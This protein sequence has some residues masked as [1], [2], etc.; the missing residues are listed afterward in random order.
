MPA[1]LF[2]KMFPTLNDLLDYLL[3]I[4]LP[5]TIQT[6]G[7]FVALAFV[8]A[9]QVFRS[10]FKRYEGLGKIGAV[11]KI[12]IAGGT[13]AI[14]SVLLNLLL[15]FLLGYKVGGPFFQYDA[16]VSDPR[17]YIF[18][19]Q[20]SLT[21]GALT[22]ILFA[23]WAY[24]DQKDELE[25]KTARPIRKIV[26]PYQL[27]G[28][29]VI[30]VGLT[31]VIGAKLFDIVEHL[32]ALRYNPVNALFKNTG[33]NY[34]GGLIFGA[35]TYLYIGHRHG[36]KLVHLADIGSPGMMLAYG[37]GRIGCQLAGD[38]DWGIVNI[39]SMPGLLSWLP[40][41]AWSSLY[42]HNAIDAGVY[43]QG[44]SGTH[45]N[46]LVQG[47][48]PTPFY[49]AV[50]CI[51]LF[52]LMWVLRKRIVLPGLMF[53]LYLV[54][55]G[56]ERLLIEFIRVNPRYELFGMHFTQA[57]IIATLML[58]GGIAGL[59]YLFFVQRKYCNFE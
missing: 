43:I 4:K 16:F 35:L 33:Y 50:L 32:P 8:A 54:L 14:V 10:E 57:Q 52:V 15:G 20:G 2:K 37:V 47:V 27:M 56:A 30:A 34:Y 29:V 1:F 3:R 42:P 11:V 41:W 39:H 18:S 9:Y 49:E 48:Y 36:M 7:F 58:L 6:L 23:L 26:H 38:G 19:F 59:V 55:C 28:T 53:C 31:G 25:I 24:L 5:I 13:S 45:C 21:A 22:A 40:G 51:G 44:C 46:Q 12:V 17:H